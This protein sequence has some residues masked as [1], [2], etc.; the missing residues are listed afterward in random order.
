MH[1]VLGAA[2]RKDVGVDIST[3]RGDVIP[4]T[5][6]E[7]SAYKVH[8][9]LRAEHNVEGRADVAVGHDAQS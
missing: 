6:L 8:A 7:L 5:R 1:V 4:E 3:D 9:F 2:D